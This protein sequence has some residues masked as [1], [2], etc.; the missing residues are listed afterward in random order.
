MMEGILGGRGKTV[1]RWIA[2][3]FG[4]LMKPWNA[5]T[6]SWLTVFSRVAHVALVQVFSRRVQSRSAGAATN[7]HSDCR[8]LLLA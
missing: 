3:L 4:A 6:K 8:R 7:M 5:I 1:E 2:G